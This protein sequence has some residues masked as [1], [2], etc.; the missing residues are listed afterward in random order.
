[1]DGILEADIPVE[2]NLVA[3][4]LEEDNL[5]VDILE[6]GILEE[7][8]LVEDIPM[9]DIPKVDNLVEVDTDILK[10]DTST[11]AYPYRNLEGN[12]FNPSDGTP[13][14]NEV[15]RLFSLFCLNCNI[16]PLISFRKPLIK[17]SLLHR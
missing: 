2:G 15:F 1:M 11:K 9:E 12:P 4:S 8:I 3:D 6:E 5:E 16:K 10:E 13:S 14:L 7:D 17:E